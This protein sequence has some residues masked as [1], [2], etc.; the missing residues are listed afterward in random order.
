MY[1]VISLRTKTQWQNYFQNSSIIFVLNK[2]IKC[3]V[4]IK[5]IIKTASV[6]HRTK[7]H[8]YQ[9]WLYLRS[10]KHVGPGKWYL[11]FVIFIGRK[12]LSKRIS[13]FLNVSY[14]KVEHVFCFKVLHEEIWKKDDELEIYLR[15][16]E[17]KIS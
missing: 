1:W 11:K 4:T 14:D 6:V 17:K 2:F 8:R 16:W 3:C 7:Y 5:I 15:K 12:I 13:Y 10:L 9:L